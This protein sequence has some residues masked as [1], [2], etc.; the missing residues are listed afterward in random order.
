MRSSCIPHP[1]KEALVIIRA[2]QVKACDGNHCAAALLSVFEYWHNVRLAQSEKSA[3]QNDI[4]EMH[5]DS[6][7][8]DESLYQFHT[9]EDLENN[10]LGLYK[11]SSIRKAIA[12]L[13][14][15]GFVSVY[16][17]PNPRYRFDRT[18]YFL[19]ET[20]AL[21]AFLASA[22]NNGTSV[23]NNSLSV[24]NNSLSAENTFSSISTEI[25]TEITYIHTPESASEFVSLTEPEPV[26]SGSPPPER[27]EQC[28]APR[29]VEKRWASSA[30]QCDRTFEPL[31]W[32]SYHRPDPDF[33]NYL[34]T[35]YLPTVPSFKDA[36]LTLGHAR[37]WLNK[38][39]YDEQRRDDALIQ[40]EAFQEWRDRP[41]A[42][43]S[44]DWEHSPKRAEYEALFNSMS[45]TRFLFP[46]WDKG[47]QTVAPDRQSFYEYMK[48][49]GA[50]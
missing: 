2:W 3:K 38:A 24:K 21:K 22:K 35:V 47:D 43:S 12:L 10:L 31:P 25:T 18:R 20:E 45:V 46:N 28:S 39:K 33:L 32:G 37:Q 29:P 44:E 23:K 4:A 36:S 14:S 8:Q 17:N 9:E 41:A 11:K 16:N 48:R 5:G 26:L 7:T 40:W 50:A 1:E 27:L 13:L 42:M 19:L 34:L 49:I 15:K 30:E 6:R